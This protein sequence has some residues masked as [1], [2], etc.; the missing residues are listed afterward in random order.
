MTI[1]G[2]MSFLVKSMDE[3]S[4]Y[5]MEAKFEKLNMSMLLPQGMLE[6][7]S[8]KTNADD[9]FS[10]ILG[11]MKNKPF[12]LTMSRNGKITAVKN[13]ESVW[14]NAINQFDHLPNTQKDQIKAQIMKAYG[15]KAIKGNME[16]VT[17]IFPDS[18]VQQGDKWEVKT[19]LEA[20]MSAEVASEYELSDL[21]GTY[22]VIKGNST[23]KTLDRD[24]LVEPNG[25]P[26]KYNLTGSMVSE[27]KIDKNTGW[28]VEAKINQDIKGDAYIKENPKMPEG[29][30][31]PMVLTNE[32][33]ISNN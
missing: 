8:E 12:D 13:I 14:E 31:I 2:T 15:E 23:I 29:M 22:A 11:A 28:I 33:I 24:A 18:P 3:S 10:K 9:I 7:S 20:G 6:F 17:A 16:M 25:M 5:N 4:G 21:S 27:I 32:T 30:K 1:N 19:N 26:M